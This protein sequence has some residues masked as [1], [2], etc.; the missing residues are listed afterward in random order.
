M[1]FRAEFLNLF[2]HPQFSNPVTKQDTPATFG[3]IQSLATNPR[4]I[5]FAMKYIFYAAA[6]LGLAVAAANFPGKSVLHAS[7]EKMLSGSSTWYS[8]TS[9]A[10]VGF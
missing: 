9:Y 2:N 6:T 10:F 4:I 8:D 7:L 3:G 1:Q 5:Q